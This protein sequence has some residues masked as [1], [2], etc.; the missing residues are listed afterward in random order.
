MRFLSSWD[1][2]VYPPFSAVAFDPAVSIGLAWGVPFPGLAVCARLGI[3]FILA[4][5]PS[6]LAPVV[7]YSFGV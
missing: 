6:I 1:L 5:A 4:I 2:R 7:D 3:C